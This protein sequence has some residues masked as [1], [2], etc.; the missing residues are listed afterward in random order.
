MINR[1]LLKTG[2]TDEQNA[3]KERLKKMNRSE[4][5]EGRKQPTDAQQLPCFEVHV[6]ALTGWVKNVGCVCMLVRASAC[7]HFT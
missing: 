6:T 2:R 1:D 7:E 4:T 3:R 5:D